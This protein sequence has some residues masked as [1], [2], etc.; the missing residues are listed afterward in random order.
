M[1]MDHLLQQYAWHGRHHV[2]HIT[3]LRA[4]QNW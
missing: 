2:G 4:R 3:A 1:S